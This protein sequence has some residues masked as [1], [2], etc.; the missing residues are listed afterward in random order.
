MNIPERSIFLQAR[1][2]VP[3]AVQRRSVDLASARL[4]V[5]PDFDQVGP[6]FHRISVTGTSAHG[7]PIT[8]FAISDAAPRTSGTRTTSATS[9]A[10]TLSAVREWA[11]NLDE[12]LVEE[13]ILHDDLTGHHVQIIA[14]DT[15]GPGDIPETF[16]N[17]LTWERE[18]RDGRQ[19]NRW[20]AILPSGHHLRVFCI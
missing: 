16:L 2:G 1:Q 15:I 10:A 14:A 20:S 4:G 18:I 17:A 13:F 11:Q 3:L 7:I 8:V 12:R 6:T 19:K 5:L 9:T